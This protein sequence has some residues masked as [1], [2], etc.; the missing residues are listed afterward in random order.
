[1]CCLQMLNVNVE[2]VN[3]TAIPAYGAL[4]MESPIA[5]GDVPDVSTA[6]RSADSSPDDGSDAK[7]VKVE[8]VSTSGD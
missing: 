2:P 7:R 3:S 8:P 1:M 4:H 5:L 6:K